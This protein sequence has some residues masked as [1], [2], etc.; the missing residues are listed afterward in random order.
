MAVKK[1]TKSIKD[2]GEKKIKNNEDDKKQLDNNERTKE[3]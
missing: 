1:Q 3:Q 2:H